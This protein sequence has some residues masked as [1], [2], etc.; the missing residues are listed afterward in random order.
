MRQHGILWALGAVAI[1]LAFAAASVPAASSEDLAIDIQVAPATL[2]INASQGGSVTVHTN[3]AFTSV[4]KGSVALNGISA[5]ATF[6]DLTGCLVAKVPEAAVKR[7]VS[8]PTAT[9]T[10]T[11]LTTGGAAFSGSAVVAVRVRP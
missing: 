3:I 4:M 11:G 2:L 7:V 8:P 5:S 10:L 1:A 6:A 9:L